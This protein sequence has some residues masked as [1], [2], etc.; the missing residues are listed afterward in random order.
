[1]QADKMSKGAELHYLL[2]FIAES[3]F[4]VEI[5]RDQLRCLWTAYCFHQNLDVDTAQYD[6]DLRDVWDKLAETEAETADWSDFDSF[7]YYMGR[8]LS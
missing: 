7:D 5:C 6:E 2:S 4:D 8:Y 3:P 1:M